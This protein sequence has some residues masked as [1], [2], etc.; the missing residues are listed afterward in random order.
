M[1]SE[2]HE[3][4][5][6]LVVSPGA[7]SAATPDSP[8]SPSATSSPSRAVKQWRR[9][10]RW[11]E[12]CW[13]VSK[14]TAERRAQNLEPRTQLVCV[15]RSIEG[16]KEL[17]YTDDY[18]AALIWLLGIKEPRGGA[19]TT[20]SDEAKDEWKAI[21]KPP[22]KH[23]E[24]VEPSAQAANDAD[25]E[26]TRAYF[27][28]LFEP[29]RRFAQKWGD[30]WSSSDGSHYTLMNTF[31]KKLASGEP[32]AIVSQIFDKWREWCSRK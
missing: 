18:S 16:K 10:E 7:E 3:P 29:H 8:E 2:V 31:A 14:Q 11:D 15:V 23:A 32:V 1:K 22:P 25:G 19:P 4:A 9:K 6:Q 28:K 24:G 5:E 13:L 27:T 30:G 21:L 26:G 17:V 12:I 20:I